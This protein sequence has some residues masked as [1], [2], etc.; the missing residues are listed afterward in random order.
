MDTETK[1]V[2]EYKALVVEDTQSIRK[3]IVTLLN[4]VGI[5]CFEAA[6]GE[7]ALSIAIE[8]A[9]EIQLL[10]TDM[11]M[12]KKDGIQL[13][14]ELEYYLE[15]HLPVLMISGAATP[16]RI[17][18]LHDIL[19]SLKFISAFRFLSKPLKKLEFY[20]HLLQF[21]SPK[22]KVPLELETG[23]RI[24]ATYLKAVKEES[25]GSTTVEVT[26][27]SAHL[28]IEMV[29]DDTLHIGIHTSPSN[30][31]TAKT[32]KE[33]KDVILAQH[34]AMKIYDINL[35]RIPLEVNNSDLFRFLAKVKFHTLN[36]GKTIV[37]S[38]IRFELIV[39]I[40]NTPTVQTILLQ[41]GKISKADDGTSSITIA[42]TPQEEAETTEGV[43]LF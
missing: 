9:S 21:F 29:E 43:E 8:K 27:E 17:K 19:P 13:I 2:S 32:V 16:Q 20:L 37:F 42:P 35:S 15:Q 41:G 10:I 38:K 25:S 39:A 26:N 34:Q 11:E 6:D 40:K 4:E 18:E 5:N 24:Y 33:F 31:I 22:S 23:K 12:P 3:L 28:H 30:P 7:E 14:Q 1:D 36:E